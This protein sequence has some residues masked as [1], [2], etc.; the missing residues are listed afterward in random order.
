MRAACARVITDP[1]GLFGEPSTT[2]FVRGVIAAT[3]ASTSQ[4]SSAVT[5]AA[6]NGLPAT[7]ALSRYDKNPN[8]W[9]STSSLGS[10]VAS[11]S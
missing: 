11:T 8:L 4:P 3:S 2:S 1:V 10:Q 6:T 9:D 5:G 7:C